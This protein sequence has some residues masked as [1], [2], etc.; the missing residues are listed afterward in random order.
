MCRGS[1]FDVPHTLA[2]L[3]LD[4][5][6]CAR[7]LVTV[8]TH[9]SVPLLGAWLAHCRRPAVSFARTCGKASCL[10]H[11]ELPAV[12]EFLVRLGEF[13]APQRPPEVTSAHLAGEGA[14]FALDQI[15]GEA[16]CNAMRSLGIA[17]R[18]HAPPAL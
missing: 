18:R 3:Q 16:D 2:L 5:F 14:D 7:V 13:P 6:C 15:V 4:G 12:Q 9:P 10:I 8:D 1:H 17:E 11:F